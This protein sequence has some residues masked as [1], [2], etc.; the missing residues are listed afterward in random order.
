MILLIQA[1]RKKAGIII[2]AAVLLLLSSDFFATTAI[3]DAFFAR[4]IWDA[5]PADCTA[6]CF[7]GGEATLQGY[8]FRPAGQS[9]A[10]VVL[11]PGLGS[12][13]EAYL[14][15]V[16]FLTQNGYTVF[17]F[18]PTG[19]GKSGGNSAL[20]YGQI[21]QD[22]QYTLCFVREQAYFDNDRMLLLGH[23]RGGFAVCCA[24][25]EPDVSG[26]VAVG[27]HNSCMDAILA[28]STQHVGVFAY[29][30]YP[31]LW[32]VQAMRT[33]VSSVRLRADRVLAQSNTPTLIFQGR[34]DRAAPPDAYSVYAYRDNSF[35]ASVQFFLY[36]AAD[37][38]HSAMLQE[39]APALQQILSFLNTVLG[40]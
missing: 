13:I 12:C 16:R 6:L 1:N 2:L 26:V 23:S 27:A 20:G 39:D 4:T 10:L 22:L 21:V 9:A 3:C 24:A 35:P 19:S 34:C 11:A 36:D 32:L 37:S 40:Q 29:C 8:L 25:N 7:P 18:D 30:N 17:C 33:G 5:V 15:C 31:M 38:S 28:A 14:G